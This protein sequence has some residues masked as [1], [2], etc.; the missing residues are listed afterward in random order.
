MPPRG[1]Y[2]APRNVRNFWLSATI[3][4]RKETIGT[5]PVRADGGFDLTIKMRNK[6]G[7]MDAVEVLGRA[8]KDGNI[9]LKVRAIGGCT[10]HRGGEEFHV[11]SKR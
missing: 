5:G 7:V 4:G 9:V 2:G 10:V 11:H 3:D 1:Y 6:G 8:D